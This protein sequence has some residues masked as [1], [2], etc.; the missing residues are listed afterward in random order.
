VSLAGLAG[1]ATLAWRHG[2]WTRL[3]GEVGP[4]IW[5]RVAALRTG[6][7]RKKEDESYT[8]AP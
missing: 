5:Q 8:L 1:L 3:H 4:R 6:T 2:T 7:N